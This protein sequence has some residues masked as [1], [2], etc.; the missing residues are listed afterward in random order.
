MGEEEKERNGG[1]EKRKR[2]RLR[3]FYKDGNGES[4]R[5]EKGEEKRKVETDDFKR[6]EG[7]E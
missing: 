4:G 1:N 7:R 2:K 5:K 6:W 3:K